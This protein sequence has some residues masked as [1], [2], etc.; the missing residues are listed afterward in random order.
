MLLSLSEQMTAAVLR[1]WSLKDSKE[2][3][4]MQKL[5]TEGHPRV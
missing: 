1:K 2:E 4:A 5:S 3:N